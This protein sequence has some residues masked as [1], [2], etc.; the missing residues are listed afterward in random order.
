MSFTGSD[1][2]YGK[3]RGAIQSWAAAMR[4]EGPGLPSV[5]YRPLGNLR[6][7]L[8]A[9]IQVAHCMQALPAPHFSTPEEP[10][11]VLGSHL[12]RMDYMLSEIRLKGNA[13]GAWFTYDSI[14]ALL[15]M[16]SFN[17]P[18]VKRTLDIF[19]GVRE[20][21]N[22]A[23]WSQT[24]IDS[25][26]IGTAKDDERPIRPEDA[27]DTALF[28]H[29]AGITPSVRD[30]RSRRLRAATAPEVKRA[31]LAALE[32]NLPHSS[33]CV[34]A[35]RERLEA[36]NKELAGAELAIQDVL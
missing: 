34:M 36:A 12:V 25:A 32:Q 4:D 13:Y 26:I 35:S 23:D 33:I 16:G 11:M 22:K 15:Y 30:D 17:D 1:A 19:A 2:A 8:A 28:R 9:P 31:M 10:L 27:T 7:G 18:H 24:E 6:E 20:W 29:L 5:D 21:V 14:G 3:V